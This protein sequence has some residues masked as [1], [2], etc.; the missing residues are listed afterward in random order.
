M[1]ARPVPVDWLLI[2]IAAVHR[3]WILALLL[4][5]LDKNMDVLGLK[6]F[7]VA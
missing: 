2:A 5:M 7:N 3:R 6:A 4:P 1:I